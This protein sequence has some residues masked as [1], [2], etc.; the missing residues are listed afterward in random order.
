MAIRNPQSAIRNGEIKSNSLRTAKVLGSDAKRK[1]ALKGA[2]VFS[3]YFQD[4]K[5]GWGDRTNWVELYFERAQY[6][7][8]EM[9]ICGC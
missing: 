3:L 2:F 8:G 9:T 1:G 5:L 6:F 7:A 4:I